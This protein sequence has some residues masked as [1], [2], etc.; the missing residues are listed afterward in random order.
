MCI[1]TSFQFSEVTQSCLTLCGPIDCRMSVFPVH[2]QLPELSQT[3]FH[4]VNDTIQLSH[5]L[6]SPSPPTFNLS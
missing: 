3:H 5:P 1:V 6:S 2:Q 4:L